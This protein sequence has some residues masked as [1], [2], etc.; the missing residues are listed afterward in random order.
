MCSSDLRYSVQIY[1]FTSDKCSPHLRSKPSIN[2]SSRYKYIS[3]LDP[4]LHHWC[5]LHSDLSFK[6]I[7]SIQIHFTEKY[8]FKLRHLAPT[9][10]ICT[11]NFFS[12]Y[13]FTLFQYHEPKPHY[14]RWY[15]WTGSFR[16]IITQYNGSIQWWLPL[17]L[18]FLSAF[19]H[20]QIGRAHV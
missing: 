3:D 1:P 15:S 2:R 20:T 16:R 11:M 14:F 18:H 4:L 19:S 10:V 13:R 6:V 17:V 8:S 12:L 5:I 7:L 9:P